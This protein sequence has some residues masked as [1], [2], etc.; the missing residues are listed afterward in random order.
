MVAGFG[1]AAICLYLLF[2]F[3]FVIY[4]LK[5]FLPPIDQLKKVANQISRKDYNIQIDTT[6]KDEIG[7]AFLAFDLMRHSIE[8][9]ENN[10]KDFV[11]NISHD[12][13]TPI[14]AIKGYVTA[15]QDGMATTPEKMDKY[16]GV[17]L[18]NTLHMEQLVDDLFLYSKL[19]VDQIAFDFA[20][21]EFKKY[22][23]YLL[24]DI[25]LELEPQGI[26]VIWEPL[27]ESGLT[28]SVDAFKMQRVI[29]NIVSNAV[30]HFDKPEKTL[31]FDLSRSPEGIMLTIADNGEGI[32]EADLPQVFDRFYR[33]DSSRNTATGSTGLGLAICQQIIQKHHG[34]ITA[35]SNQHQGTTITIELPILKN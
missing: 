24:D 11:A 33:A 3:F 27:S 32:P 35:Q 5:I 14:T 29:N 23:D 22:M 9:Y 4:I 6:R 26:A 20:P 31:R 18:N 34:T 16:V 8:T 1:F 17:I 15:I 2:S 25:R 13:K 19:D 28:C 21:V 10:R 12:L 30:K 7:E